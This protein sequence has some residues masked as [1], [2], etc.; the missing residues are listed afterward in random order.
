LFS[1]NFNL[2]KASYV[3]SYTV[4]R[5]NILSSADALVERPEDSGFALRNSLFI[6]CGF[7]QFLLV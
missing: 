3:L 6:I 1:R 7:Q 2:Q 5:R 4:L